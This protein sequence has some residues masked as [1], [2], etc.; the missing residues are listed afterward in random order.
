MI[1]NT[2]LTFIPL[3]SSFFSYVETANSLDKETR[4]G[5]RRFEVCDNVD[6]DT[7]L[8]E[9]ESYYFVKFQKYP[10]LTKK[11]PEQGSIDMNNKS[12]PEFLHLFSF[13]TAR[14]AIRY[15][16]FTLL[17]SVTPRRKK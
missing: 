8:M 17:C 16:F 3:Y 1:H 13:F 2:N 4:F 14:I 5:L 12:N 7:V 6:L 15:Y 11:V 9:Y 10:K